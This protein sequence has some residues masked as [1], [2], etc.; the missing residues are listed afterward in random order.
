MFVGLAV[1]ILGIAGFFI[2]ERYQGYGE[3]R[4][5][6]A[7]EQ[8][9]IEAM[10]ED[11]YGGK[12]PQETLNLFVTA[13][14][15][16]DVDLASKYF[17]LDDNLS[18]EKWLKTL[19]IFKERGVLD[20]MAKDIEGAKEDKESKTSEEDFK[21]AAYTEDGIV[22]ALIDMWFNTY[23]SIWKIESL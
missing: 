21:F 5:Y 9:Y 2:W 17:M 10:T 7:L 12:T 19:T 15:A 13:L 3:Y 18:R 20:D 16:G 22:G 4:N 23:S 1:V 14:K 8:R 11:I 6:K